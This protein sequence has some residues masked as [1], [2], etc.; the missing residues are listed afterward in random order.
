MATADKS[1]V[2]L[3]LGVGGGGSEN[4][5]GPAVSAA[6]GEIVCMC[7]NGRGSSASQCS[8]EVDLEGG[9]QE[10]KIHLAKSE[11]DCRIYHLSMD[12][13]NQEYGIPIELGFGVPAEGA[14]CRVAVTQNDVVLPKTTEPPRRIPK[15]IELGCA[16]K[17]DLAAAHKQCAEAWFKIK[18]NK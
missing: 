18:G 11:R 15:S 6:T 7:E 16:C 8:V 1:A 13:A 10:T 9:V 3:E 5:R 12:A 17:E 14:A 2:D 4:N